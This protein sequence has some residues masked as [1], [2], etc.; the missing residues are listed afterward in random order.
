MVKQLSTQKS[1]KAFYL[2]IF[3][4]IILNILIF[5][6]SLSFGRYNIPF[7]TTFKVILNKIFNLNMN[8]D[9]NLEIVIF[10]IR[11]PRII[12]VM[13]VG[14]VLSQCGVSFQGIFNNP[15]VSPYI[16]GISGGAGFG[17][18]LGI[19][20]CNNFFYVSILSFLFSIISVLLTI[21]VSRTGKISSS[22]NL[23]LSG[24]IIGNLF[25]SLLSLLKYYADPFSKLPTIDFW[26]MGSFNSIT[27]KEMLYTLPIFIIGTILLILLRWKLNILSLGDDE[28]IV[29]GENPKILKLIIISICS[30]LTAISVSISGIIGW[31]GLAVPH[32]VRFIFGPDYRYLLPI[33]ALFGSIYLL[34][35]DNI[36]RTLTTSEIPVGILTAI[37]G[38]PIFIYVLRKAS[39]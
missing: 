31:V 14:S 23:V 12:V 3:F 34:L 25:T 16:L 7:L 30:L 5:L 17:A 29:L 1:K 20:Y 11:L 18:A 9:K 19:L 21:F 8:L 24:F 37:I 28:A 27:R 26:L 33:S 39:K 10:N 38:T 35:I 36:S 4:L 2:T 22:I 32:I 15:L 6:F 13:F